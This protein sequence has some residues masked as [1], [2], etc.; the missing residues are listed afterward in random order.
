MT[1]TLPSLCNFLSFPTTATTY[2]YSSADPKG[3]PFTQ[4]TEHLL[5]RCL[6]S[7]VSDVNWPWTYC[8]CKGQNTLWYDI[9]RYPNPTRKWKV[10]EVVVTD[11]LAELQVAWSFLIKD[12]G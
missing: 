6:W 5:A 4:V 10:V 12:D 9:Y 3:E 2:Y 8:R 7:C 1:R 11:T